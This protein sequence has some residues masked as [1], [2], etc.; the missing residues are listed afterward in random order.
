M[1]TAIINC[2]V[3]ACSTSERT[4]TAWPG[5][6]RPA[7]THG[8]DVRHATLHRLQGQCVIGIGKPDDIH[9]AG[10]KKSSWAA[11]VSGKCRSRCLSSPTATRTLAGG[12]VATHAQRRQQSRHGQAR[13]K[14]QVRRRK[15]DK[16]TGCESKLVQCS[17]FDR[18]RSTAHQGEPVRVLR[19]VLSAPATPYRIND[20][21]ERRW[22]C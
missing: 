20:T 3:R 9:P 6:A 14:P 4:A 2:G 10:R 16:D 17:N 1:E 8:P 11:T 21:R 13:D 18:Y 19:T 5:N 12:A 22:Q 7:R 15:G